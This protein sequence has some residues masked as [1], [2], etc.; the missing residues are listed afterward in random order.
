M[1][2]ANMA[3]SALALEAEKASS[4]A[5]SANVVE[6]TLNNE[7]A[8]LT[9]VQW[10]LMREQITNISRE[11]GALRQ[12]INTL[13]YADSQSEL[14]Q[15]ELSRHMREMQASFRR[16]IASESRERQQL[17]AQFQATLREITEIEL[18]KLT[19]A[20]DIQRNEVGEEVQKAQRSIQDLE[21]LLQEAKSD[22]NIRFGTTEEALSKRTLGDADT[23]NEL[24]RL[25]SETDAKH[26]DRA[27]AEGAM[28]KELM[29]LNDAVDR[30]IASSMDA[31]QNT[32]RSQHQKAI[33]AALD[34]FRAS[35]TEHVTMSKREMAAMAETQKKLHA[36]HAAAKEERS[37]GHENNAEQLEALEKKM[38]DNM[39]RRMVAHADEHA[40]RFEEKDKRLAA[41]RD[42]LAAVSA[43]EQDARKNHQTGTEKSLEELRKSIKSELAAAQADATL[44]SKTLFDSHG[45]RMT[46]KGEQD[47]RRLE[48]LEARL[49][50][51]LEN[52]GDK[53]GKRHNE[54]E[55]Q[56]RQMEKQLAKAANW[57]KAHAE[58]AGNVSEAMESLAKNL[59]QE[60]QDHVGGLSGMHNDLLERLEKGQGDIHEK[61]DDKVKEHQLTQKELQERLAD[62]ECRLQDALQQLA[63]DH[64]A[65]RVTMEKSVEILERK[66][67]ADLTGHADEFGD[68]TADIKTAL[69]SIARQH[70]EKF[71]TL[72]KQQK[73]HADIHKAAHQE[74]AKET[75]NSLRSLEERLR[76]ELSGHRSDFDVGQRGLRDGLDDMDKKLK[77]ALGNVDGKHDGLSDQLRKHKDSVTNLALD[78]ENKHN[79]GN[80]ALGALEQK[81]RDDLTA[82]AND[83]QGRHSELRDQINKLTND[84]FGKHS[85]LKDLLSKTIGS[86]QERLM[87]EQVAALSALESKLRRE[88]TDQKST[89]ETFNQGLRDVAAK[90]RQDRELLNGGLVQ[91]LEEADRRVKDSF[92]RFVDEHE[93]KL[94][95][96]ESRLSSLERRLR[97]EMDQVKGD[98]QSDRHNQL[99]LLRD[100]TARACSELRAELQDMIA[101]VNNQ[102]KSGRDDFRTSLLVA[103]ESAETRLRRDITNQK[104]AVDERF[105]SS[106]QERK[107]L[108]RSFNL[109]ND[110]LA[111]L[112][113]RLSSELSQAAITRDASGGELRELIQ[114][115]IERERE[116]AEARAKT[117]KLEISTQREQLQRLFDQEKGAREAHQESLRVYLTQDRAAREDGQR[118]LQE[119]V[120]KA[121]ATLS[122]QISNQ[123]SIIVPRPEV[124]Q[125]IALTR[126]EF[127][128]AFK[129]LLEK[130]YG[131]E[132][133]LA[134]AMEAAN[135]PAPPIIVQTPAQEP[136][137][138]IVQA[139]PQ[140]PAPVIVEPSSVVTRRAVSPM[141]EV[142]PTVT[143]PQRSFTPLPRSVPAPATTPS[144]L[145]VKTR[146]MEAPM[147]SAS[148][149]TAPM[150]SVVVTGVDLNGD[151]IPDCLQGGTGPA[152]SFSIAMASSM[153]AC[154]APVLERELIVGDTTAEVV[155]TGTVI[156]PGVLP[157]VLS[158]SMLPRVVSP[159]PSMRR[160]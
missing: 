123:A 49:V 9:Q 160:W 24:R 81:L 45:E 44:A 152:S 112:D 158:S 85:E 128:S 117:L 83:Q 138:V 147:A 151:G 104:A 77:E 102:E 159:N 82:H 120:E 2:F 72:D 75:F 3:G 131:L 144:T 86:L 10:S 100:Q 28:R 143:V 76:D 53:H 115:A 99:A 156:Q 42:E 48:E 26:R 43:A 135:K 146:T 142:I 47:K 136:T 148:M 96:L 11:M 137:P 1:S 94:S 33:D 91:R 78:V 84:T 36:L 79:A 93:G 23:Y 31:M 41:L 140:P 155:Q 150:G 17:E 58:H 122:T 21:R 16:E 103:V 73:E 19:A 29:S 63:A 95:Q 154:D 119:R 13:R 71:D 141:R 39:E 80:R 88:L 106:A 62:A 70:G 116:Q 4:L 50:A 109:L 60:F 6:M 127:D 108:E 90:E 54:L 130:C 89:L 65:Y 134:I 125:A 124:D 27:A 126:Q 87:S 101:K 55:E 61:L 97:E 74:H 51:Q 107:T 37:A 113:M 8:D 129:G 57:D 92:S 34:P 66:L 98:L 35:F 20:L 133:D 7:Q 5:M 111:D 40:K 59:R 56:V 153:S 157:T 25:V 132:R 110:R 18:S 105:D 14:Q 32:V 114:A 52:T 139:P 64:E 38:A 22:I 145:T 121:E 149:A 46:S 12:D 69:E 30:R 15:N 118:T 68:R 67:L